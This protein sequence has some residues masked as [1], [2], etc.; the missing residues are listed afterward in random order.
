MLGLNAEATGHAAQGHGGLFGGAGDFQE[1]CFTGVGQEATGH[2][3]ATP[4]GL[5]LGDGAVDH[6][7]GKSAHLLLAAVDQ[8]GLQRKSHH[9]AGDKHHIGFHRTIRSLAGQV[10]DLCLMTEYVL[11]GVL[12]PLGCIQ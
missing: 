4:C 5:D 9:V 1:A 7:G 8:T 10:I 12:K 3:S 11:Q 6:F 2:E